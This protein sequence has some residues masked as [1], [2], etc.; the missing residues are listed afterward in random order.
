MELVTVLAYDIL[1]D[2]GLALIIN[3]NFSLF[4][5]FIFLFDSFDNRFAAPNRTRSQPQPAEGAFAAAVR[6]VA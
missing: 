3:Y 2:I 1:L 5:L 6:K 4:A